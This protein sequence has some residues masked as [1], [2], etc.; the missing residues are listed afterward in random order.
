MGAGTAA[1]HPVLWLSCVSAMFFLLG[2]NLFTFSVES[3]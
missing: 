2:A 1:V 3:S